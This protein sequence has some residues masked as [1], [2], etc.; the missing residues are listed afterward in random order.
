LIK[1]LY[2]GGLTKQDKGLYEGGL[3]KQDIV[4]LFRLLDWMMQ[5]PESLELAF[6]DEIR[7]FEE[8]KHMP[9]ISSIERLGREEGRQEG[10]QEE[11]EDIVRA[12]LIRWFD[13]IDEELMTVVARLTQ[14]PTT[15]FGNALTTIAS[16]T[17]EELLKRFGESSI[18]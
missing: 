6:R 8:E 18:H 13:V 7:Q 12:L 1:G 14:M 5:L 15:E 17:R 11:R 4:E 16:I 3:T 10:R 2:E 9:Y